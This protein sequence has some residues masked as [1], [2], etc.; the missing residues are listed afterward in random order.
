MERIWVIYGFS[1]STLVFQAAPLSVSSQVVVGGIQ[2]TRNE[3]HQS[4]WSDT[5]EQSHSWFRGESWVNR[6]M[7]IPGGSDDY[8]EMSLY[9][10]DASKW[11]ATPP[12]FARRSTTKRPPITSTTQSTS[13]SPSTYPWSE[14]RSENTTEWIGIYCRTMS[15][16]ITP[17]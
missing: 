15:R 14:L 13:D 8:D 2:F 1:P 10:Q 4:Q 11:P 5:V 16:L 9:Q 3:Y 12:T 17:G 7:V 6:L